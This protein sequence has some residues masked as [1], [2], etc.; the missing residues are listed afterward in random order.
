[1]ERRARLWFNLRIC[2]LRIRNFHASG[3]PRWHNP[4]EQ[5]TNE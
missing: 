5:K 1:M 3:G 2:D 4:R